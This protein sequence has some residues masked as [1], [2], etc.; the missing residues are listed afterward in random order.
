MTPGSDEPASGPTRSMPHGERAGRCTAPRSKSSPLHPP[1]RR[2]RRWHD[3]RLAV[4]FAT[5]LLLNAVLY[6]RPMDFFP[7]VP[8]VYDVAFILCF[9]S[10]LPALLTPGTLRSIVAHPV[11][12]CIL[13]VVATSLLSNLLQGQFTQA[14]DT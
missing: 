7:G 4:D 5:F 11:S 8:G 9:V 14:Y 3:P 10:S 6:I 12:I 2:P 1:R 13:G